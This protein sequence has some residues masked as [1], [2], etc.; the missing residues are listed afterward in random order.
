[1]AREPIPWPDL[2]D[3]VNASC[4]C[5]GKGPRDPG[6]CPACMV[7]HRLGGKL[8]DAMPA[9]LRTA[10]PAPRRHARITRR[11]RLHAMGG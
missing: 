11:G 1:M 8:D 3:A 7:W 4:T 6:V 9:E 2:R 5:G 10:L